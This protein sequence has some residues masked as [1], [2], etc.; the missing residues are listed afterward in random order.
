MSP[1]EDDKTCSIQNRIDHNVRAH[2]RVAS[3][4]DRT[5]GEIFNEFEQRRLA[6]SL[7]RC[8]T[9]VESG[10][11][12]ALDFGCGSGNL[13]QHLLALDLDVVSA[14][15]S[16]RFLELIAQRFP[17]DR[18]KPLPLNGEN[19]AGVD[20]ESFDLIATYSVLHHVPDYLAA[21]RELARVCRKGGIVFVDHEHSP[22]YW[23]NRP[24]YRVFEQ[25]AS[26]FDLGKFLKPVNYY[27]KIRRLLWD[28]KYAPEGDIH[29]WEDDH[30]EWAKV[31]DLM[32]SLGFGRVMSED[33]LLYKSLYRPDVYKRHAGDLADMRAMAFR[34]AF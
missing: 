4:Y 24:Q 31:E 17:A 30:I 21:L 25:Q 28:P 15:V 18:V 1:Y 23:E 20:D 13:T 6:S 5:H 27:G 3:S 33:Y 22:H 8:L 16:D 32:T 11:K 29:V 10:G 26:Q 19:L 14:D 7:M 2:N 34:K 12:A 9:F